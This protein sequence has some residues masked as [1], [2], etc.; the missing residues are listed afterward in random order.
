MNRRSN[1]NEFGGESLMKKALVLIILIV[2]SFPSA[3]ALFSR[4]RVS[5]QNNYERLIAIVPMIGTGSAE[6]PRRPMFTP[7]KGVEGNR[8]G[9]IG[10]SYQLS[11]D[12]NYALVEFVGMSRAAFREILAEFKNGMRIFERGK[13]RKDDL[14]AAWSA[15]KKDFNLETPGVNLP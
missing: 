15:Y 4:P 3:D 12:E 10:F 14:A 5:P 8:K 11:D 13:F 2:F 6:D 7:S 9:L 1:F